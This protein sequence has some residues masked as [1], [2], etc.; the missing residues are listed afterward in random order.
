MAAPISEEYSHNVRPKLDLIDKL[1]Q[2]LERSSDRMDV[3]LPRIAVVGTQSRGKSTVLERLSGVQLPRG[4]DLCTRVPLVLS[5]KNEQQDKN[6]ISYTKANGKTVSKI[7]TKEGIAGAVQKGTVE[8]VGDGQTIENKPISLRISGR[9]LPD[10]TLVDLPGIVYTPKG[11]Q[12]QD[13]YQEVKGLILEY[14]TPQETIVL[15]VFAGDA[16]LQT[17]EA[18][19][20]ARQVD[21]DGRRTIGLITR[22]DR[23]EDSALL[24]PKL[25][26]EGKHCLGIKLGLVALRNQRHTNTCSLQKAI[27]EETRFFEDLK[28]VRPIPDSSWGIKSLAKRLCELQAQNLDACL[29]G[30]RDALSAKVREAEDEL[31]NLKVPGS[32]LE[33]FKLLRTNYD[34]LLRLMKNLLKTNYNDLQD[35]GVGKE[36][37]RDFHVFPR[38]EEV[39]QELQR[40]LLTN[41]P[42]VFMKSTENEIREQL[43]EVS[44]RHLPNFLSPDIFSNLMTRWFR[45]YKKL[46]SD[47]SS[48]AIECVEDVVEKSAKLVTRKEFFEFIRDAIQ[49][50]LEPQF[51]NLDRETQS[52]LEKESAVVHTQNDY[53]TVTLRKLQKALAKGTEMLPEDEDSDAERCQEASDLQSKQQGAGSKQLAPETSYDEDADAS[54]NQEDAAEQP[55][56]GMLPARKWLSKKL[57]VK[58]RQ[59]KR[60]QSRYESHDAK[61]MQVLDLQLSAFCYDKVRRKRVCD[62]L[63]KNVRHHLLN[64]LEEDPDGKIRAALDSLSHDKVHQRLITQSVEER[65]R[66]EELEAKLKEYTELLKRIDGAGGAIAAASETQSWQRWSDRRRKLSDSSSPLKRSRCFK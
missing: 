13:I 34:E 46:I 7:I 21:P 35:K 43:K 1:Q 19:K 14:I 55:H 48:R 23:I 64:F 49:S 38:I 17:S 2:V 8:L 22:V 4:D 41:A 61:D 57:R 52:I 42:K 6:E 63:M 28:K 65:N 18:L 59:A 39:Q 26:Q 47:A 40:H 45:P 56:D 10:L 30:V 11:D 66:R 62:D 31:E 15:C 32:P 50:A 58:P 27:T 3:H 36:A 12:S 53:Y 51:E 20:L 44:G 60:L 37:E 5:I 29:P 9:G 33:S 54:D 24:I 25:L 16:D